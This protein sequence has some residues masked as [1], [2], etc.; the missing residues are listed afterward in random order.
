[1]C[2]EEVEGLRRPPVVGG[3]QCRNPLVGKNGSRPH[4][5]MCVLK[6]FSGLSCQAL[7]PPEVGYVMGGSSKAASKHLQSTFKAA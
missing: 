6:L 1:M 2:F 5:E 7:C 3:K 4:D